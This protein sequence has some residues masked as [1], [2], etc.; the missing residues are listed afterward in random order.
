MVVSTR[1]N[2]EVKSLPGL[3]ERDTILSLRQNLLSVSFSAGRNRG[4][5][6]GE[7]EDLM[8]WA[9][10]LQEVSNRTRHPVEAMSGDKSEVPAIKAN[11]A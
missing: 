10:R 6:V 3:P 5:A 4:G 9:E 2:L 7:S 11:V 1:L 8:R